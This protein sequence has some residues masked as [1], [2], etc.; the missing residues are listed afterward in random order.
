ML[1]L[2]RGLVNRHAGA[3]TAHSG[4]GN[5]S[6]DGREVHSLRGLVGDASASRRVTVVKCSL[7]TSYSKT[8]SGAVC[9]ATAGSSRPELSDVDWRTP[10]NPGLSGNARCV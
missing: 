2:R 7:Y 1:V 5:E 8:C 4:S 3:R 6:D 9:R 10:P